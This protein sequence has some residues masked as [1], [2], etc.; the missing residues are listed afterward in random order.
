MWGGPQ[1]PQGGMP[2]GGGPLG[3]VQG[4]SPDFTWKGQGLTALEGVREDLL[5]P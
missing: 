2:A 3:Q 1:A 4:Q 5:P